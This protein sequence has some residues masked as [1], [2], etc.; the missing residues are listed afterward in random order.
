MVGRRMSISTRQA[1][2]KG[3]EN[4]GCHE[5]VGKA[6]G[7]GTDRRSGEMDTYGSH[8]ATCS[9]NKLRLSLI[10]AR[11]GGCTRVLPPDPFSSRHRRRAAR[12]RCSL[13]ILRGFVAAAATLV[14]SYGKLE[15][16]R[17]LPSR[18]SFVRGRA[19]GRVH[20]E[21]PLRSF[22][23]SLA[24]PTDSFGP[25]RRRRTDPDRRR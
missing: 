21:N 24:G 7:K 25:R 13:M 23:L 19:R 5:W 6:G 17:S 14:G 16:T 15:V 22:S 11:W 1:S 9:F 3:Q 2:G 12:S 4:T 18:R 8:A 20:N 10:G